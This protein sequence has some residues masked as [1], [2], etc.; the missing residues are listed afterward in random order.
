MI[1]ELQFELERE[2]GKRRACEDDIEELR[3]EV[4]A[5]RIEKETGKLD[6]AAENKL[7]EMEQC[8][9][10]VLYTVGKMGKVIQHEAESGCRVVVARR[11]K[12]TIRQLHEFRNKLEEWYQKE[13]NAKWLTLVSSVEVHG[14]TFS[15]VVK[16]QSALKKVK[17]KLNDLKEQWDA[18]VNI[19]AGKAEVE[20]L[21]SKPIQVVRT[22]VVNTARGNP[23]ADAKGKG[24]GKLSESGVK[25]YWVWSELSES[26]QISTVAGLSRRMNNQPFG[27]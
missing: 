12:I 22:I 25:V 8:L 14:P 23:K 18:P 19:F 21:I 1:E 17:D 2:K 11:S 24:K 15:I 5:I 13:E 4:K 20:Q 26:G 9:A 16:L 27:R 7:N 6:M 3:R 10:A